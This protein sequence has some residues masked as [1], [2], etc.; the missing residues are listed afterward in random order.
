MAVVPLTVVE[1][2]LQVRQLLLGSLKTRRHGLITGSMGSKDSRSLAELSRGWRFPP[3]KRSRV[4][5]TS[6]IYPR[7]ALEAL[8]VARRLFGLGEHVFDR[9]PI[10]QILGD[11]L[12]VEGHLHGRLH[13]TKPQQSD[14]SR[15]GGPGHFSRPGVV[16]SA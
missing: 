10:D 5:A 4:S 13:D 16:F 11:R 14:C 7:F 6:A 12:A 15:P 8:D 1:L 2:L 9:R 3:S